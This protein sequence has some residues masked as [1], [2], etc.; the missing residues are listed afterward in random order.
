M[1]S[2][3]TFVGRNKNCTH[4]RLPAAKLAL[5]KEFLEIKLK[6]EKSFSDP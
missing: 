6:P 1:E 2:I 4:C 3:K 5:E